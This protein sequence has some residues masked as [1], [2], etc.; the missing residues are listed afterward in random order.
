MKAYKRW[1]MYISKSFRNNHPV[2]NEKDSYA[3][4]RPL[5]SSSI[6]FSPRLPMKRVLQGG[7]SFVFCRK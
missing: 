3:L 2:M 4:K 7:L 1:N 6:I 5:S